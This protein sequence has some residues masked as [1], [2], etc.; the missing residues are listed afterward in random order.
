MWSIMLDGIA[1][2][3]TGAEPRPTK[4]FT[5]TSALLCR[6]LP[7]T[8]TR[9]WSGASPRSV[10]GRTWSVPSPIDVRGKLKLG[11]TAWIICAVSVRPVALISADDSTSIGTGASIT[12]RASPRVPRVDTASSVAMARD[13]GVSSPSSWRRS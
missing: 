11:A 2:R 5:F 8:S 7:F 10:A 4:P 9:V 3:S 6:R 1:L 13:E 12:V